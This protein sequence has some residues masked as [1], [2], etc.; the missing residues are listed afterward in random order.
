M[1]PISFLLFTDEQFAAKG[2]MDYLKPNPNFE[3]LP[4]CYS[5][6][7][8][9]SMVN[10]FEPGLLLIDLTHE[11]TFAMLGHIRA[12]MDNRCMALW[13]RTI[14]A[15]LAVQAY[16][17]GL[18]G[19]IRK[20]MNSEEHILAFEK[21]LKDGFWFEPYLMEKMLA[22][23]KIAITKRESQLVQ[24]IAQAMKNKEIAATLRI[25]EGTVKVYLSRLFQK[26][27]VKDRFELALYALRN[28]TDNRGHTDSSRISDVLT[29]QLRS[30]A[31]AKSA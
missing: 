14:T 5:V 15:E 4:V 18:R 28:L 2:L 13:A 22:V 3:V 23:S 29:T 31:F 10:E 7:N 27:G 16:G 1:S 6:D 24:L 19:V 11:V 12:I 25:S 9:E 8:L 30:F 17:L 26:L 21:I 20:T